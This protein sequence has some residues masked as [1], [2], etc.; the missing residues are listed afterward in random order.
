MT[1]DGRVR[2]QAL[3]RPGGGDGRAV[4]VPRAIEVGAR[5]QE[6]DLALMATDPT[7]L[8]NGL[9]DLVD[10]CH[11]DGI[12]VVTPELLAHGPAA[13]PDGP[14]AAAAIE[15]TRRLR[16]SLGDAT[17]LVAFIPDQ[18]ADGTLAM[19]KAFL[20]AGADAIVVVAGG[21]PSSDLRT[22]ANVARFHRA[23]ALALGEVTGLD[24]VTAVGFDDPRPAGAGLVTTA[25]DLPRDTD[26]AELADWVDAVRG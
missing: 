23:L 10:A 19:G 18:G 11:P 13:G 5:V 6:R 15:A 7:Q 16:S 21:G 22:L 12:P 4:V 8:A 9:R 26:I 17:A 2:L 25:E 1:S 3:A 20:G 14:A 24:P